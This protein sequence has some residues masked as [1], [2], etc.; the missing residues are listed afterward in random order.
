LITA[1]NG[2]QSGTGARLRDIQSGKDLQIYAVE[3]AY[4]SHLACSPDGRYLATDGGGLWDVQTAEKLRTFQR[5]DNVAPPAVLAFSP[6]SK[7]LAG[8]DATSATVHLWDVVSGQM[9]AQYAAYQDR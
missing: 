6:D 5:P 8:G 1:D 9:T 3:N 4:V 7:Q 2:Q